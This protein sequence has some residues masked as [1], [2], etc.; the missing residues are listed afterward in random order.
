MKRLTRVL[1][2]LLVVLPV[3]AKNGFDLSQSLLPLHHIQHGGPPRDGI[4]AIDAPRFVSA[5]EAD[6]LSDE[7][8]VL[9]LH[10]N[11]ES[12]AYPIAI[13]NWHEIVNDTVGERAVAVTF[14]PLCGTGMAFDA[15]V[16][17][18]KR[19]FGVSGLL[20]QSDVLLYDR[21]SQSLWSQLMMQAISGPM[22]GQTLTL[23]PLRHTSWKDWRQAF[24]N[25]KVLSTET[26]VARDYQRDPYAGYAQS[27]RVYFDTLHRAP[28]PYHPKEQVLGLVLNGQARAWP[29][30]ELSATG[31]A[32]VKE[33]WQGLPLTVEWREQARTA[34]VLNERGEELPATVAF[35]FAWHTFYPEGSVY[36]APRSSAK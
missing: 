10:L 34:R 36:R 8:R 29:F 17:G 4:P 9:G 35:W 19:T 3:W 25:T 31:E 22:A 32:A 1:L 15:H 12:K 16:A 20:Y 6:F 23:L 30:K 24:P 26:G 28:P 13:M 7:D 21:Q 5:L 27:T 33:V 14:C 2:C 11:G 18:Q